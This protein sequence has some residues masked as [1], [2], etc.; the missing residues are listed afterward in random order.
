MKPLRAFASAVALATGIGLGMSPGCGG[1]GEC[2]PAACDAQC[3]QEVDFCG[4]ALEGNCFEGECSC[5]P[6][7]SDC[8]D[9]DEGSGTSDSAASEASA[10]GSSESAASC[11]QEDCAAE[12]AMQ[13]DECGI[14]LEGSCTDGACQCSVVPTDCGWT[15]GEDDGSGSGES[16]GSGGSS[17]SGESSGSGGSSG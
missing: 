6:V 17:G 11:V 9:Y 1:G 14:P 10:E 5:V 12:C 13:H 2:N 4:H 15:T 8:T 16:S 3:A 7:G